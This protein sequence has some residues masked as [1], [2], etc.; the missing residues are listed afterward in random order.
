MKWISS[1]IG[2]RKPGGFC[3][4]QCE[5]C[6]SLAATANRLT[7]QSLAITKENRA[8]RKR[9]GIMLRGDTPRTRMPEGIDK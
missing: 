7:E 8:L 6:E 9:I 5:R 2:K 4:E 1:I 3:H